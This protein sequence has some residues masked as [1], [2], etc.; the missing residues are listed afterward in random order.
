MTKIKYKRLSDVKRIETYVD[1][2]IEIDGV[3]LEVQ[4]DHLS[5]LRELKNVDGYFTF[6]RVDD[7]DMEK[8]LKVT[9]IGHARNNGDKFSISDPDNKWQ[10]LYDAIKE[11]LMEDDDFVDD[12]VDDFS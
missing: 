2:F 11:V 7:T 1:K 4:D 10:Q 8:V 5:L 3:K 12:F 9:K 6:V